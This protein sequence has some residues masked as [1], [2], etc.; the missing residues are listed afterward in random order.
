MS[1]FEMIIEETN[2]PS[3]NSL[4]GPSTVTS[5]YA[6]T[7]TSI[8]DQRVTSTYA[9]T[10][11]STYDQTV[12]ST[13][14]H[15]GNLGR[16][17]RTPASPALLNDVAAGPAQMASQAQ[18]AIRQFDETDP[19][20]QLLLKNAQILMDNKEFRL[21]Q[22]LLRTLLV[23]WSD[24]DAAME[25]MGAC[26]RELGQH[27]DSL[28]CFRALLKVRRDA[29]SMCH[30]A[31]SLYLMQRD[32]QA[33]EAYTEALR[34]VLQDNSRLFEAYKNIGNIQTRAGDFDAAEEAYNKAYSISTNSDVLMVN[35]GTLEIQRGHFAEAIERF[36]RAVELNKEN[37]KAWTGLAILH[38]Q[39]GDAELA[40]GNVERALDINPNN[41]TALRLQ[42][43]WAAQDSFL[44]STLSRLEAYLGDNGEDAEM[45]FTLAK[46]LTH[47]GKL[48]EARIEMERVLALD[49]EMEGA[50]ALTRILDQEI[51]KLS[52]KDVAQS[53][54]GA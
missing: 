25:K 16:D 2:W 49:P 17:N 6:P 48:R 1:D 21:A 31:E 22:H 40:V 32:Q 12:T 9:P 27:E 51:I 8:Y 11:T 38:R 28:K 13:D 52:L 34:M 5:N 29:F 35:Y 44:S 45:A 43:D 30:V 26:L 36:R 53:R 18:S 23:R 54:V 14:E 42:V 24:C 37:D 7:V 39:M 41:R 3:T 4:A 10:V 33:L 19:A 15:R 47:Q 20:V 50:L 46:V